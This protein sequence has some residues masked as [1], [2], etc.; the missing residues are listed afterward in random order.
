MP[1]D[2]PDMEFVGS[3]G[4]GDSRVPERWGPGPET[5]RPG[6]DLR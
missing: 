5:S 2:A 1:L 6:A 4:D 3:S